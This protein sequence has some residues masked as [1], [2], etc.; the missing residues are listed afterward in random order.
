MGGGRDDEGVVVGRAP[1]RIGPYRVDPP[2]VL[3][4]MAGI[5]NVAF[6]RLF[7]GQTVSLVGTQ[8]TRVAVPLQV[9]GITRSSLD[10][11]LIELAGFVPLVVFGLYGARSPTRSIVASWC[12]SPRPG[13]C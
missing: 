6:R 8:V 2:V 5:T 7:A 11:G 13:R 1:L 10:V 4:P 12:W 3:A 9:Y